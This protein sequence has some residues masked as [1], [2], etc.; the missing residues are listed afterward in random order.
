MNPFRQLSAETPCMGC[1]TM[2]IFHVAC[3]VE[4]GASEFLT[5]DRRQSTLAA[6]ANLKVSM[7]A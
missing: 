2:D 5:F 3:A 7:L 4:I 1:R 6:H